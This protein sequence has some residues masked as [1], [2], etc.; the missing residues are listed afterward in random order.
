MWNFIDDWPEPVRDTKQQLHKIPRY[1]AKHRYKINICD[2]IR[3]TINKVSLPGEGTAW[4]LPGVRRL[5][6]VVGTCGDWWEAGDKLGII[7]NRICH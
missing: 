6:E 5:G 2:S 7:L 3:N 4:T 1:R